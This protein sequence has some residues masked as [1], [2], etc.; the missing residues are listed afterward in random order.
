M[1]TAVTRTVGG[2]EPGFV[3]GLSPLFD[4]PQGLVFSGDTLYVA[5]SGNP[6]S[7]NDSIKWLDPATRLATTWVRGLHEPGGV[8]CAGRVDCVADTNAHRI[9]TINYETGALGDLALD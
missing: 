1:R 4:S 2:A 7:C 6:G 9:A 3:E 5:D 8:A